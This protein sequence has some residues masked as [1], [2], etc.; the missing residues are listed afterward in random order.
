MPEQHEVLAKWRQFCCTGY[1]AG[2]HRINLFFF[3]FLSLC[4]VGGSGWERGYKET[5]ACVYV[6]VCLNFLQYSSLQA[7]K[8]I[9]KHPSPL[10]WFSSF[11]CL[12]WSLKEGHEGTRDV[13][14]SLNFFWK[15]RLSELVECKVTKMNM[16][17]E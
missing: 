2:K 16:V 5:A 12:S 13:Q 17:T 9:L 11:I 15:V 1:S 4:T 3:C 6:S 10:Q 14:G 7:T 8:K